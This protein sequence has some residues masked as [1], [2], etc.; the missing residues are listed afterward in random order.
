LVIMAVR[1]WFGAILAEAIAI[2]RSGKV[3]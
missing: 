3:D 2:V 1:I